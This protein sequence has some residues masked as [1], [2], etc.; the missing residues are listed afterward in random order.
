MEKSSPNII[1]V[2]RI[3]VKTYIFLVLKKEHVTESNLF[4]SDLCKKW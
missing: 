2:D 3:Q 4:L 1:D